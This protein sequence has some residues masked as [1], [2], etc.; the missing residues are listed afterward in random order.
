MGV[1]P[2]WSWDA[3]FRFWNLVSEPSSKRVENASL[4]ILFG[5]LKGGAHDRTMVDPFSFNASMRKAEKRGYGI[6]CE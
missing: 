4:A 2:A 1:K 3:R 6:R 5:D